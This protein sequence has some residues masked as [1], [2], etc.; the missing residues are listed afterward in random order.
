[1]IPEDTKP[2]KQIKHFIINFKDIKMTE[3]RIISQN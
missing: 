1:M 2:L 3:T